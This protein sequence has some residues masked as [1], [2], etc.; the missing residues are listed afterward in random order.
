[1]QLCLL[2]FQNLILA[3]GFRST[4]LTANSSELVPVH[5]L[6]KIAKNTKLGMQKSLSG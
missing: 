6:P 4:E 5:Y 1:M 2:L 3:S